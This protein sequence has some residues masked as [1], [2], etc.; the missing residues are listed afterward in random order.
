MSK[1]LVKPLS[2]TVS[3][4]HKSPA[5]GAQRATAKKR[6]RRTQAESGDPLAEPSK[7]PAGLF[8][9]TESDISDIEMEADRLAD[10]VETLPEL[11]REIGIADWID[12]QTGE[13]AE[14]QSPPHIEN[15]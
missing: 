12:P 5:T 9:A 3:D 14:G 10:S 11:E 2:K 8:G 13:P 7:P 4:Q 1:H 15:E 6:P